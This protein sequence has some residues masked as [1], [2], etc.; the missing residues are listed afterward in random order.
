MLDYI[1]NTRRRLMP[2]ISTHADA[3][4]FIFAALLPPIACC[5]AIFH[6]ADMP[7]AAPLFSSRYA[8][9][10]RA[11]DA[12]FRLLPCCYARLR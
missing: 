7:L 9:S 12:A 10:C 8:A 4:F 3:V 11:T 1:Y 6:D 2:P 5:Y